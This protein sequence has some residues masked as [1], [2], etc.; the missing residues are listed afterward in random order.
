MAE[1]TSSKE[2]K[3]CLETLR[4]GAAVERF[5]DAL[6]VVF[7]NMTDFNTDAK[8]KRSITLKVEF[9]PNEERTRFKQIITCVSK[10]APAKAVEGYGYIIQDKDGT[11]GLE[12]NPEQQELPMIGRQGRTA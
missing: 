1:R 9:Q 10:L 5:N 7:E 8:P 3:L 11:H 2:R 4:E 12:Y 6:A